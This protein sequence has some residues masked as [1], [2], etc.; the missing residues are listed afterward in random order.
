MADLSVCVG[1]DAGSY[2]SKLAYSDE[3]GT[4]IL[5]R[6]EGFDLTALREEAE[7]F[8][9]EPVFSCVAA[10]PDDGR[11]LRTEETGF[12]EVYEIPQS[13]AVILGLGREGRNI[14]CDLGASACRIYALDE[15]EVIDREEITDF[16]GKTIDRDF[17]EYIA[18]RFT[19][20]PK[21]PAISAETRRMKH[22]LTENDSAVWREVKVFRYELE[23]L[24]HFPAKKTARVLQRFVRVHKPEGLILTG[25]S[26]KIPEV[27]RV[28]GE[29]AGLNPEYRGNLIA[30]GAAAKAREIQKDSARKLTAKPDTASRLRELRADVLEIEDRLTR[31]QKDRVYALFR[32]AEGIHDEGAIAL[33]ENLIREIRSV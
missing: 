20:N 32:Q 3:L 9:E 29:V 31:R 23:R 12:T 7:A 10:L 33:M 28:F 25:G 13:E 30:E 4:R 22:T 5:A 24:I 26:M 6:L 16:C 18:E 14:V 11:R 2:E 8:C 27:W 19:L 15:H 1:I 17:G 21:D